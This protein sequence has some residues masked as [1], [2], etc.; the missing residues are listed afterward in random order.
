MNEKIQSVDVEAI[1][2]EIRKNIEDRGE[3]EKVLSF[4]ET[5][6]SE[7][8]ENGITGSV[9]YDEKAL[10]RY[11]IMANEDHNIPYYQMIPRGGIKSFIKRSI[12]KVIAF[13]VLPLRDAQNRYN[14]NVIQALW[15]LEAYTLRPADKLAKQEEDI[16][17]LT[18]RLQM[19]EKQYEELLAKVDG[20]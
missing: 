8:C 12:R 14:S 1:M 11:L 16:E 19:L 10:R 3:T 17:K 18:E 20:R 4:D 13:I 7:P 15:Q 2:A 9:D 6:V 5:A